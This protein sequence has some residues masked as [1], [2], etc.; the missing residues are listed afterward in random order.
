MRRLLRMLWILQDRGSRGLC[1]ERVYRLLFDTGAR[2]YMN[3]SWD[4]RDLALLFASGDVPPGWEVMRRRRGSRR[5]SPAEGRRG[6]SA[7]QSAR[8]RP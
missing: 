8:C 6:G 3:G 5:H 7:R 2:A 4:R 1:L